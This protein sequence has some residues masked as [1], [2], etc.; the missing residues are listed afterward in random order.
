MDDFYW[1]DEGDYLGNDEIDSYDYDDDSDEDYLEEFDNYELDTVNE[2]LI[3]DEDFESDSDS[4]I[5]IN[6]DSMS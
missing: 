5:S 2:N 4:G 1:I 6:S 3:I